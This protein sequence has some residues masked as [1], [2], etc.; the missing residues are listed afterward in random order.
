MN[1]KIHLNNFTLN[2]NFNLRNTTPSNE[3]T[4]I[5]AVVRFNNQRVVISG[6]DKVEPRYW[7]GQKQKPTQNVA[8]DRSKQ[9]SK[10]ISNASAI[11]TDIFE[12][13]TTQ[14]NKY[15]ENIKEFQDQCR[16]EIFNLPNNTANKE[17]SIKSNNFL[18][19]L[20]NFKDSVKAGKRIISSGKRKGQAYAYN[21]YKQYG[22]L[23]TNIKSYMIH[24]RINELTFDDI[25]LDFYTS[26]REYCVVKQGLTPNYFGTLVKCIKTIM[27]DAS[28]FGFHTS[29]KFK[30]RKF[31]KESYGADNVFLDNKKLDI[32]FN[33]DLTSDQKLDRTRDLFLIGAYTGLRFSDFSTIRPQDISKDYLRVKTIKTGERV[34]IPITSNLR[35]ILQK[36]EG[37]IPEQ[38][39]NQKFNANLKDLGKAAEFTETV[40]LT[41]YI[42]GKECVVGVP[43][44]QLMSSHTARRSF[45]T[46]M[47]KLGIPSILIMAITG[48]TTEKAFLT[49]I[50][51]NNDDKAAMMLDIIRRSELKA[52]NGGRA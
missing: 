45:A 34:T 49:Y 19:Y 21:T 47:F 30:S 13:Y 51:M 3:L 35:S 15:P 7:N 1:K 33:L 25:D 18:I 32:L 11:I 2:V 22:S 16:R 50:K 48:H 36:H 28:E 42:K 39:S 40:E 38:I 5:N 31:I 43:F 52:V 8:N 26:F 41:K 10:N 44:W 37:T 24:S 14:F 23:I 29:K 4:A 46:N 20:E 9:I 27:N 6:I 17:N 12:Q